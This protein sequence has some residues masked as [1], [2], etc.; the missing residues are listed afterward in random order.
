MIPVPAAGDDPREWMEAQRLRAKEQVAVSHDIARQDED[1]GGAP[2]T[3]S[4]IHC[5]WSPPHRKED[6]TRVPSHAHANL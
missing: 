1:F 3:G 5:D 2:L 6:S 4:T